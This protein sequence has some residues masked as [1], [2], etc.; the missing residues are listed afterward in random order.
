MFIW[1][2]V[3]LVINIAF[4]G[5]ILYILLCRRGAVPAP[6]AH[7]GTADLEKL[8]TELTE[9][10]R[11]ALALGSEIKRT[12]AGLS[13]KRA[14]LEAEPLSALQ[15]RGGTQEGRTEDVYSKALMMHSSGVPV[16]EIAKV[17]GL[18]NGEAEL[19]CSLKRL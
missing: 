11:T 8:R 2:V 9:M 7:T 19:L 14:A 13:G 18:F 15:Y 4:M 3:L 16:N 5:G 12:E 6:A 1:A 17:L 10:R